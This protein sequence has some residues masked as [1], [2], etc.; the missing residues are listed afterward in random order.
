M[1]AM[2]TVLE[3]APAGTGKVAAEA[4]KA[5]TVMEREKQ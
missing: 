1:T 5:A 2:T 4:V 3:M